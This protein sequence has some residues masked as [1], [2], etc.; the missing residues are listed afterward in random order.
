M[1]KLL[2]PQEIETFYIIPTLRRYLAQY[3]KERGMKQK[4]VA[5]LF[6]VHSAAV[7]Q[8]NSKRGHRIQFPPAV[9]E[10]IKIS[11]DKIKDHF[12][13]LQETQRILH[14]IRT[15]NTLCQIHKQLSF[16]PL[17]C[18]PKHIGCHAKQ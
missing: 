13:Y 14:L 6:M 16:V 3:L 2:L 17:N 12:T 15:T 10:E 5:Y 8:Y 9:C 11:A 18:I 7:S 4:D 1:Q